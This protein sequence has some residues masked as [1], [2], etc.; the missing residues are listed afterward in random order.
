MWQYD[1]QKGI[2]ALIAK[3][4]KE[5]MKPPFMSVDDD[6]ESISCLNLSRINYATLSLAKDKKTGEMKEKIK[7][8]GNTI[9]S[10]IMPEYIFPG[11][12]HR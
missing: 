6:G 12:K 7:L 5:E 3:Y 2:K 10:K 9:K 8:T 11:Q 4:N 1:G